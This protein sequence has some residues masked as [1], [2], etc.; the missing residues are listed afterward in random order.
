M[1]VENQSEAEVFTL[2]P[3]KDIR[4]RGVIKKRNRPFTVDNEYDAREL[5]ALGCNVVE[6]TRHHKRGKS[7]IL[8]QGYAGKVGGIETLLQN[9]AVSFP[10]KNITYVYGNADPLQLIELSKHWNVKQYN[11]EI[12]YCDILISMMFDTPDCVYDRIRAKKVYCYYAHACWKSYWEIVKSLPYWQGFELKKSDYVDVSLSV[13]EQ[14]RK[15]MVEQWGIESTVIP[16]IVIKQQKP[17]VFLTL[18][19]LSWEKGGRQLLEMLKR[20]SSSGHRFLWLIAAPDANGN[21]D[22]LAKLKGYSEVVFIEASLGS[23]QLVHL[24]DYI[25]QP[26]ES[27]AFCYGAYEALVEGKPV[28][29]LRHAQSEAII[30]QGKNGYLLNKDL[31]DLDVDK[32][33]NEIPKFKPLDIKIDPIWNDLLSGKL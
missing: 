5:V 29:M 13:S 27:E 33:F 4:W 25:I 12:L 26:S 23:R 16:N 20:F 3:N 17:L 21:E 7:I 18:S 10:D 14:A 8:Y 28:I 11:N 22:L 6:I 24:A 15:E 19:R 1:V 32:I 30:K 9:M 2:Q 31:S